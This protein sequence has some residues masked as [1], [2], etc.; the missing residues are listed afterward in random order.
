MDGDDDTKA[1]AKS[2]ALAVLRAAAAQ[3]LI[4]PPADDHVEVDYETVN[5]ARRLVVEV[6]Y[7]V[8]VGLDIVEVT[9]NIS[10][11]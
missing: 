11:A 2:G 5:G 9:H 3:K 7:G 1:S 4:Q 6:S 8:I 10:R